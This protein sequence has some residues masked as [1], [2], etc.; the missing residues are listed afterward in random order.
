MFTRL[1]GDQDPFIRYCQERLNHA[2]P[3]S[4]FLL[5]PVQRVQKYQLLLNEML[6]NKPP[7]CEE[8]SQLEAALNTMLRI[9]RSL[10]DAM[11]RCD[12]VGYQKVR[13]EWNQNKE[14]LLFEE[15]GREE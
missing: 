12:I 5:K 11:L 14:R 3:L 1:G 15:E 7:G 6:K 10:N 8:A 2:L 9:L 13:T 4:A